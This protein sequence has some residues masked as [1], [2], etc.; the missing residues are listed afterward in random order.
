MGQ[1][2]DTPLLKKLHLEALATVEFA[3][4]NKQVA[5][6]IRKELL[7]NSLRISQQRNKIS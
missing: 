3:T 1:S 4:S 5:L 6:K 2:V 7:T